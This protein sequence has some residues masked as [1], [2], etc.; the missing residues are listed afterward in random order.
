M[1]AVLARLAPLAALGLAQVLVYQLA[2]QRLFPLGQ[3]WQ[4]ARLDYAW[5]TNYDLGEQLRFLLAFGLQFGLYGL[6]LRTVRRRPAAG[7]LPLVLALQLAQALP[8]VG[9]YPAAALDIFD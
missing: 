9:S 1:A 7:P 4:Y 8:L 5:L 2:F 6:A 3:W